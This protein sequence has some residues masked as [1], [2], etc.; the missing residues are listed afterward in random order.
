[1]RPECV[2][3]LS[4]RYDDVGGD[5]GLVTS[6]PVS[7]H[8]DSGGRGLLPP[9]DTAAAPEAAQQCSDECCAAASDALLGGGPERDAGWLRGRLGATVGVDQ[10]GVDVHRGR[11]R[12]VAGL[13]R[14]VGLACRVGAR[15][16]GGGTG[17]RDRGV[18]VHQALSRHPPRR[19]VSR[20]QEGEGSGRLGPR[21][22]PDRKGEC[23]RRTHSP[24]VEVPGIEPGSSVASPGL[25]RAQFAMPLL[26]PT[27]HANKP[28]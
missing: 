3:S 14:R 4:S 21:R 16:R 22:D 9:T 26:G 28:M 25:L 12:A 7:K 1:M 15:Q 23:V 18:A 11:C 24:T 8:T 20:R 13:R 27:G 2:D 17:Q 10:P 6:W 19:W 5:C